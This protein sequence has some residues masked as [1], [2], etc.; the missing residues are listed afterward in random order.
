MLPG[1]VDTGFFI[2]MATE[3]FFGG[4]SEELTIMTRS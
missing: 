4:E 3:A 2:G 1:V